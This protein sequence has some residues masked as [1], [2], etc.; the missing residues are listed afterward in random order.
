MRLSFTSK[1]IE[2]MQLISNKNADG[3]RLD[4]KQL[5]NSLSY[6]VTKQAV[7]SSV[8]CLVK[9]GLIE[10]MTQVSRDGHRRTPLQLTSEGEAVVKPQPKARILSVELLDSEWDDFWNIFDYEGRTLH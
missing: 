10:R 6:Q 8:N 1:Q 7:L 9:R 4:I 3:S 5:Q 2:I